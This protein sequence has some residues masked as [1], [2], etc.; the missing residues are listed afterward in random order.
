MLPLNCFERFSRFLNFKTIEECLRKHILIEIPRETV[1]YLT[2]SCIH[3]SVLSV[4][5]SGIHTA[6][7]FLLSTRD[8][9]INNK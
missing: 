4:L 5:H 2:G 9:R 1:R 8:D 6:S 3:V 7:S